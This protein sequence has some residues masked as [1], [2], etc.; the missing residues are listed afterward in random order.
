MSKSLNGGDGKAKGGQAV[1]PNQR[2]RLSPELAEVLKMLEALEDPPPPKPA[3]D[4][5]R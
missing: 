2:M 4:R 1:R 3:D 5:A